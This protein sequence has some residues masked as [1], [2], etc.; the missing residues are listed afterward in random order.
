MKSWQN[1]MITVAS[2]LGELKKY[3]QNDLKTLYDYFKVTTGDLQS[4]ADKIVKRYS[5]GM[6]P[7][8]IDTTELMEGSIPQLP[9]DMFGEITQQ[10]DYYTLVNLCRGNRALAGLCTR[11]LLR[12]K[13]IEVFENKTGELYSQVFSRDGQTD[14]LLIQAISWLID[15]DL[16]ILALENFVKLGIIP[17][18]RRSALRK[19]IEHDNQ[20]LLD[21]ILDPNSGVLENDREVILNGYVPAILNRNAIALNKLLNATS[22]KP[23]DL[24][25][26]L[27]NELSA[28]LEELFNIEDTQTATSVAA[29]Y[30]LIKA[31]ADH[32]SETVQDIL[33]DLIIFWESKDKQL[34]VRL[35][36]LKQTSRRY[37]P[38]NILNPSSLN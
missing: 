15:Q 12:D 28:V 26:S 32:K 5:I 20:L 10:S 4:L 9:W 31:G 2:I 17:I 33:N 13:A 37:I 3:S 29:A 8:E 34:S 24:Q 22:G 18:G 6:M 7:N 27:N 1:V 21:Y 19:A 23:Q 35:Q 36:A 14:E 11:K 25:N 38:Q 30:S 16:T